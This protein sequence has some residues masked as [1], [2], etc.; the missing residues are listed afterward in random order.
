MPMMVGMEMRM[1]GVMALKAHG[2]FSRVL[3]VILP[4]PVKLEGQN[5]SRGGRDGGP[6]HALVLY[7]SDSGHRH[8]N[9]I[10]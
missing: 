8:K 5:P 7:L 10:S 2:K 1:M 3:Y 4:L 6:N 9:I